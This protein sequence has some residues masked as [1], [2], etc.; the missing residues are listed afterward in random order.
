MEPEIF[1]RESDIDANFIKVYK[2]LLEQFMEEIKDVPLENLPV[3]F[4]PVYGKDYGCNPYK[5]AFVGWETRNNSNLAEFFKDAKQNSTEALKWFFEA[6]DDDLKCTTYGNKFGTGFWDF[7]FKFLGR[8]YNE[9]W[10]AIKNKQKPEI[11]K[12][13]IWGNLESIERYEVSAEGEGATKLD[14]EKI[15]LASSIYD[16]SDFIINAFNPKI[17]VVLHWQDDDS[18]LTKGNEFTHEIILKD[19]LEYYYLETTNTH[20]YWTRHP[21]SLSRLKI[22]FNHVIINILR[23][24]SAKR[25]YYDFPGIHFLENVNKFYFQV[26]EIASDLDLSIEINPFWDQ[27]PGLYFSNPKWQYWEIGF[28]FEEKRFFGG[29]CWTSKSIPMKIEGSISKKFEMQEDA[30]VFWPYWFWFNEN[31]KN[32]N[33]NLHDDKINENFINEIMTEVKKM[34]VTLN[35]LEAEGLQL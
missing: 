30:T 9:N 27:N 14:W 18:W 11:L 22:D 2:P 17:I 29:I 34:L 16:K 31:Y 3:P 12:S 26:K 19:N 10:K 20:V 13:F 1:S 33:N 25:I 5:I 35:E 21:G 32:W 6:F 4:I 7:I 15:K 23:S 8:F 28:E 24:I